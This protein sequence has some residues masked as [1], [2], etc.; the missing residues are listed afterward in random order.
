M[1]GEA[2][3]AFLNVTER[4]TR[5]LVNQG[6][7]QEDAAETG[8]YLARLH[9][10]NRFRREHPQFHH[11]GFRRLDLSGLRDRSRW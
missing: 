5:E 6:K 2:R 1:E 8:T 11:D 3:D 7:T 10:L 9:F 4:L